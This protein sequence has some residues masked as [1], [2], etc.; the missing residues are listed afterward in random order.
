MW[1]AGPMLLL[2]LLSEGI[3]LTSLKK[4]DI[5]LLLKRLLIDPT[6]LD[7]F[8]PVSIFN[9]YRAGGLWLEAPEGPKGSNSLFQSGSRCNGTDLVDD[10]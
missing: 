10:F 6:E 8:F 4:V 7:S 9:H 5:C 3:V 1:L 2:M